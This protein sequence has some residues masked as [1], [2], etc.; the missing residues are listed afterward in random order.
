MAKASSLVFQ[1]SPSDRTSL[2]SSFLASRAAN[3]F[4]SFCR[5]PPS[6]FS[7]LFF[8]SGSPNEKSSHAAR[9]TSSRG[10]P[11]PP[12]PGCFGIFHRAP[13]ISLINR[14]RDLVPSDPLR[15][16]TSISTFYLP[17]PFFSF[18]HRQQN[19]CQSPHHQKT[20]SD[21]V[22][23]FQGPRRRRPMR[24]GFFKQTDGVPP[25]RCAHQR[26]RLRETDFFWV[27]SQEAIFFLRF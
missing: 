12:P 20:T 7:P 2:F 8:V 25:C 26:E 21:F 5:D 10:P 11:F 19:R 16:A 23:P 4:P 3:G 15:R 18:V 14:R 17:P 1:G 22:P 9:R 13:K 6:L 27:A 24:G